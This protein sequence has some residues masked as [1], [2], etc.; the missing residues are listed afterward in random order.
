MN[1]SL[2]FG[3]TITALIIG[4]LIW[5]FYKSQVNVRE[6]PALEAVPD[7]A[8]IIFEL[9]D[10][11]Q[12]WAN[13]YSSP[14]WNELKQ[15][16]DFREFSDKLVVYDS[17][18]FNNSDFRKVLKNFKLF[19]SIHPTSTGKL[20][21]LFV[22]ELGKEVDFK[23]MDEWLVKQ[24]AGYSIS[25]RSFNKVKIHEL[26]NKNRKAVL[27]YTVNDGL[28]L[29]SETGV[30]VDDALR[31]MISGTVAQK[32]KFEQVRSL[33][34][35]NVEANVYI[36]Y[37]ALPSLFYCFSNKQNPQLFSFLKDFA[38]SSALDVR[39]QPNGAL[40]TGVTNTGDSS[41][42][43]LDLFK[44]QLPQPNTIN[45]VIPSSSALMLHLGISDYTAFSKEL[46]EYLRVKKLDSEYKYFSDSLFSIYNIRLEES[47]IPVAGNE[48]ALVMNEPASPDYR[49]ECYA[50]IKTPNIQVALQNIGN[51]KRAASQKGET[52]SLTLMY[53]GYTVSKLPFGNYLR[54]LYGGVFN[55]IYSPF[56]T[57]LNDY[58]IFA[59]SYAT[60]KQVID[61][62]E[63]KTV[64]S[65]DIRYKQYSENIST[66][67]NVLL[68]INVP[69]SL[70][71]PGVYGSEGIISSLNRNVDTYRKLEFFTLQF[72]STNNK[73]FYS[74][75]N[76]KFNVS[77]TQQ[78]Q[79]AESAGETRALWTTAI[80]STPSVAP[81][82]VYD[83]VRKQYVVLVQDVLNTLYLLDNSG[84]MVWDKKLSSKI[85]GE[86]HEVDA[87]NNGQ[88]QYLFN[89]EDQ[90][91]LID[92]AGN[93]MFSY[94]VKLGGKASGGLTLT[95]FDTSEHKYYVP[96]ENQNIYGYSIRGKLL[97][98][99]N[100]R[101]LEYNIKY[102]LRTF[103][104]GSRNF[105][106]SSTERGTLYI[107]QKKGLRAPY[108]KKKNT[109]FT[110][111][112][113]V[114]PVDT[115]R[116]RVF[117]LDT[118]GYIVCYNFGQSGDT[119]P[120]FYAG[121][122]NYLEILDADKDGSPELLCGGNGSYKLLSLNGKV[123]STF[124]TG[125]TAANAPFLIE[126]DGKVK[127]GIPSPGSNKVYLFHANGSAYATF[128]VPGFTSF[129]VVDFY[130]NGGRYF[131]TGGRGGAIQ[132]MQLK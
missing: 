76:F 99:W 86:I 105:L 31:K 126:L 53:N 17:L 103:K 56:I 69:R 20:N 23:Y 35:P 79:V 80:D 28:L 15:T 121:K 21:Y 129:K 40:L 9:N 108:N 38:H 6:T 36:N 84:K 14:F 33:A 113:A 114:Q 68:Y 97:E 51:L 92:A 5:Y 72:S 116:A 63:Q 91:Y 74:N 27:N 71:L 3:V 115:T 117:A 89:T 16:P 98:G 18:V 2:F 77:A 42:G 107:W 88:R 78:K 131:L 102:A 106:Y 25:N 90:I 39:L 109:L 123:I 118:A 48:A 54:L 93:N 119:L 4:S 110:S 57:S 66:T 26:L 96:C 11:T 62:Y 24:N 22:V 128:P 13:L 64:L 132:L 73:M 34:T 65:E 125:D 70:M 85:L 100:P 82:A 112:Y 30:L 59:N 10:I 120:S 61:K 49:Q 58:L 130:Q 47:L 122:G 127:I 12:G 124:N 37:A 44:S 46:Q 75:L 95:K 45:S 50:V 55:S 81:T 8:A 67:H 83:P 32:K 1:K 43:Y 94:P 29:F 7:D 19:F 101:T 60:L 87:M 41:V 111:P 52:D 104:L